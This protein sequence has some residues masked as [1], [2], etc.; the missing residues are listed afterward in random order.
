[1]NTVEL[2]SSD[3]GKIEVD[4][5][6]VKMSATLRELREAIGDQPG[7]VIPVDVKFSTLQKVVEYLY[8]HV[9]DPADQP[10]HLRV[11]GQANFVSDADKALFG[12]RADNSVQDKAALYD[13]AKASDALGIKS[14]LDA[15][16]SAIANQFLGKSKEQ[17]QQLMYA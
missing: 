15:T 11:E 1:M 3:G 13:L 4:V 9:H 16:T 8:A 5:E 7:S 10:R 12:V 6:I 17:I 14:L 2:E